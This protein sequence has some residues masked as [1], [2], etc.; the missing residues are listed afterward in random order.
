[1]KE[2]IDNS[3][4]VRNMLLER[5]IHPENLPPADDIKK[6]QRKLESDNKKALGGTQKG[7]KNK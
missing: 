6:I 5:G 3:A 7:R 2:H 4:A 1:M